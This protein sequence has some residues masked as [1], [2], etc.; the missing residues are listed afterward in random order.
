[1]P[2]RFLPHDDNVKSV[3]LG[4][5]TRPTL[6]GVL[7][8]DRLFKMLDRG[9]ERPVIWMAGDRDESWYSGLR[10]PD[11]GSQRAHGSFCYRL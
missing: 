7:P 6:A 4:K 11:F 2:H 3:S 10:Y 8:R 5:T 9:R 1:M